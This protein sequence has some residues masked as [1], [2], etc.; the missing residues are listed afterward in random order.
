[1]LSTKS[2]PKGYEHMMKLVSVSFQEATEE[3]YLQ[4]KEEALSRLSS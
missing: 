4:K 3:E 2:L 1:M